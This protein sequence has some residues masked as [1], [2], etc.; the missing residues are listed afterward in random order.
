VVELSKED[1][2]I[3]PYQKKMLAVSLKEADL[4]PDEYTGKVQVYLKNNKQPLDTSVTVNRRCSV[5]KALFFLLL[6]IAFGGIYFLVKSKKAQTDSLQK[7]LRLKNDINALGDEVSKKELLLT[8]R[9]LLYQIEN[10]ESEEDQASLDGKISALKTAIVEI[11]ELEIVYARITEKLGD[12]PALSGLLNNWRDAILQGDP[13]RK[14]EAKAAFEQALNTQGGSRSAGGGGVDFGLRR[15]ARIEETAVENKAESKWQQFLTGRFS[16]LF[17][18]TYLRPF[19]WF[20]SLII[21]TWVGLQQIYLN[22][23][24][25]FGAEGLYDYAKL[26]SW[27]VFSNIATGSIIDNPLLNKSVPA[28]QTQ[29]G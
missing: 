16:I 28:A 11:N 17:I 1:R 4:S 5:L 12:N 19:V 24:P 6:G 23:N 15:A 21:L 25:A 29:E 22:G 2:I 27:G 7:V 14:E 9:S 18:F 3:H 26:L 10:A 13:A 20:I 8:V